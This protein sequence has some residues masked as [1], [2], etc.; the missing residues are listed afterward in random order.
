MPETPVVP[1]TI[2]AKD[3]PLPESERATSSMPPTTTAA[4]DAT[5]A[6]QRRVSLLWEA[7]Q[8]IIAIGVVAALIFVEIRGGSSSVLTTISSLVIGA[9]FA[10]T[11]HTAIGGVGKKATDT[12]PYLGR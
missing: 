3:A 11:N 8:G 12:Q 5:H 6:G 1:I 9:Y 7:T 4:E 2:I 10:R